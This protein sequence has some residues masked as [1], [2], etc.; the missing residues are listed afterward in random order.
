MQAPSEVR[1]HYEIE[2]ELSDR[3]RAARSREERRGLYEQVYR[4]LHERVAH[5][6]LVVRAD[7]AAA[8]AAAAAPQVRL[9][10]PFLNPQSVFCEI[11]AGDAAVARTLAPMVRSAV[12]LD[13]TD[14]YLRG[15]NP[16]GA[17]E[18]RVFDGFDPGLA[19]ASV[20]L[21]YSRDLVEHLHPDDMREQTAAIARML[22]PG[23]MYVC[24]TPNRLWGPHDISR[25]FD[26][27]PKGFHL[28][29]YTSTELARAMREAGFSDVRLLA[30]VGGRR[31]SPLLPTW[32][33][34][35]IESLVACLPRRL[36]RR[37]GQLLATV[38]VIGI[39]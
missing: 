8:Q 12:A 17:F 30:S 10:R 1:E 34:T 13:V 9:L 28:R 26:A 32:T 18:F 21:A 23:G 37:V 20:D 36:R 6:P 7:D 11:G 35:W 16:D 5:H 29:E 27:T 33:A 39:R 4:E 25:H 22:K 38:K 2:R 15:P 14:A 24:V 3:L 19:P 31:I